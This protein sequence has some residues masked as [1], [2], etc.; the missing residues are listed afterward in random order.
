MILFQGKRMK[1]ED[2]PKIISLHGMTKIVDYFSEI[3]DP[4]ESHIM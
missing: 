4:I 2:L 1:I 3:A